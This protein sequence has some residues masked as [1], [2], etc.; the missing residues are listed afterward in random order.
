[1]SDTKPKQNIERGTAACALS[2][3]EWK[4]E[5]NLL[6]RVSNVFRMTFCAE[7]NYSS[8][9]ISMLLGEKHDL[10]KIPL[11]VLNA[12]PEIWSNL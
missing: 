9:Q 1:M 4:N 3:S 11:E 2:R 6:R 5:K 12:P 8:P 7:A 10:Q